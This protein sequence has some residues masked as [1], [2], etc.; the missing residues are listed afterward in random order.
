MSSS[1]YYNFSD[2]SYLW[3]LFKAEGLS[4]NAVAGLFG[5]LYWES[6]LCPFL[7]QG[8]EDLSTYP[9]YA[10]SGFSQWGYCVS[11]VRTLTSADQFARQWYGS[12][13]QKGY[14]LAQWTESS[15]KKAFFNYKYD[16]YGDGTVLWGSEMI[17]NMERDGHYLLKDV[18][19]FPMTSSCQ[20]AYWSSQGK[21]TWQWLTDPNVSIDDAT[22]AVLLIFERPGLAIQSVSG[23]QTEFGWRRPLADMCYQDFTGITP[24]PSPDPDP[25]TPPVPPTPGSLGIKLVTLLKL[26]EAQK[27]DGRPK[28]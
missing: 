2:V 14:G 15:R 21:T 11:N 9:Y 5:N 8:W 13:G 3:G 23:A 22:K 25:P 17:G 18:K 27:Q 24:P 4:D 12:S 20:P 10:S 28:H 7:G 19:T 6:Y 16:K 1:S 26:K